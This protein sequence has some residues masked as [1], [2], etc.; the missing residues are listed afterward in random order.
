MTDFEEAL[1]NIDV[2]CKVLAKKIINDEENDTITVEPIER[3]LHKKYTINEHV[4]SSPTSKHMIPLPQLEDPLMDVFEDD[5]YV[6]VLMQ[7]RCKD[8]KVTIHPDIEGLEICKRECYTNSDGEE[9]CQDNC[10]KLNLQIG[11]LQITNMIAK[12]NNNE[13]LEIEIPKT[14]TQQS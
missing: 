14:K 13:V 3:L 11:S 12:C 6:K 9:V 1:R 10:R 8:E 2:F 5:N 4:E 7:C